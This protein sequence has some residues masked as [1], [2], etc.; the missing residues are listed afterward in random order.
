[1]IYILIKEIVSTDLSTSLVTF[2]PRPRVRVCEESMNSKDMEISLIVDMVLI[3][4]NVA[5]DHVH[6]SGDADI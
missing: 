6:G 3:S 5:D 4:T 1:M 2:W